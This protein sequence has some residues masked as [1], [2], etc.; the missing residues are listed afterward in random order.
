V[1]EDFCDVDA[2]TTG[3]H[4]SEPAIAREINSGLVRTRYVRVEQVG[5]SVLQVIKL[6]T[7]LFTLLA[8]EIPHAR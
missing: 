3:L 8:R 5:V 7:G 6:E 1:E 4:L 2:A